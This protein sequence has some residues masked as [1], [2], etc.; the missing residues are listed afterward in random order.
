MKLKADI[1]L[2]VFEINLIVHALIGGEIPAKYE[3]ATESLLAKLGH[4]KLDAKEQK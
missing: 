2:T 3:L 1:E 4:A